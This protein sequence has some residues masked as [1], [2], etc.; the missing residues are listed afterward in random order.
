MKLSFRG[1]DR[2]YLRHFHTVRPVWNWQ[3]S[4]TLSGY[5]SAKPHRKSLDWPD[6][7]TA[8]GL[9]NGLSLSGNFVVK[10]EMN[11]VELGSLL[12]GSLTAKP[13]TTQ[14]LISK[15]LMNI[16]E[17]DP[18]AAQ[19]LISEVQLNAIKSLKKKKVSKD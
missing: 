18:V 19:K 13:V 6:G 16:F 12:M 7:K 8:Y 10:F 9:V 4:Q 5:F 17:T 14:K 2:D 15:A 3:R 1:K 11:E